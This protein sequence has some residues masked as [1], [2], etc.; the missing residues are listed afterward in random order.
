[1]TTQY[2]ASEP[3]STSDRVCRDV[4]VCTETQYEVKA[5]TAT[6]DRACVD[7]TVCGGNQEEDVAPNATSD[8]TCKD[9]PQEDLSAAVTTTAMPT[10]PWHL[11]AV[12]VSATVT[13]AG[14]VG[15]GVV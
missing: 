13:A 1:M 11:V 7:L 9:K 3:T 15:V 5:P 6:S 10:G 4:S 12:L 8:R 2:E 14:L